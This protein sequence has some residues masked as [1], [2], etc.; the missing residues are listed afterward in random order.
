MNYLPIGCR[1]RMSVA[2][3]FGFSGMGE[4]GI[5]WSTN[6]NGV[7]HRFKVKG[8]CT[9]KSKVK[10]LIKWIMIKSDWL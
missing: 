10:H 8:E 6:L 4:E 2:K 7:V 5:V 3:A 9:G 1:R